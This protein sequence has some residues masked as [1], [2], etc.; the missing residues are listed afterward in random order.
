MT[1]AIAGGP[2]RAM[3]GKSRAQTAVIKS[4]VL[5]LNWNQRRRGG[6]GMGAL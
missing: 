4:I 1:F 6:V 2:L 3:D 5:M